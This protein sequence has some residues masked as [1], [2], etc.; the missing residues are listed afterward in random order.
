MLAQKR[1]CVWLERRDNTKI[2]TVWKD[3]EQPVF[4]A[5]QNGQPVIILK[6]LGNSVDINTLDTEGKEAAAYAR[7]GSEDY[8]RMGLCSMQ[9]SKHLKH[10][11]HCT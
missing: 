1:E 2:A 8:V 5:V 9:S 6:M 3:I 11:V 7:H 4:L 10:P